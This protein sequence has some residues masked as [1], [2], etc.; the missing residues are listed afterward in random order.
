MLRV[1]PYLMDSKDLRRAGY[2]QRVTYYGQHKSNGEIIEAYWLTDFAIKQASAR[3]RFKIVMIHWKIE[4]QGFNDAK[5]RHRIEHIC[6]HHA[7]QRKPGECSKRVERGDSNQCSE[8]AAAPRICST[9]Q[10]F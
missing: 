10:L 8:R 7:N 9:T 4:N 6:H 5:T 1:V 3:S 2:A